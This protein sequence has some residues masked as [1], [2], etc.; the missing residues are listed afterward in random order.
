MVKLSKQLSTPGKEETHGWVD[1]QS[2]ER[3]WIV[4]LRG[5]SYRPISK[6]D[7]SSKSWEATRRF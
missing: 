2:E 7:S 1:G 3:E 6:A 5:C 4:T